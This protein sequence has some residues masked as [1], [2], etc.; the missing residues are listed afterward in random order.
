MKKGSDS[1]YGFRRFLE[2]RGTNL[3]SFG[4]EKGIFKLMNYCYL[5]P[6]LALCL[7]LA[8][9]NFTWQLMSTIQ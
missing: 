4:D 2:F 1:F 9:P 3:A 6:L 7:V 5:L 8:F